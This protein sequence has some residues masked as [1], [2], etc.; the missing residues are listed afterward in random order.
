MSEHAVTAGERPHGDAHGGGP[1]AGQDHVAPVGLYL[2]VFAALMVL[3]VATVAASRVD[4]GALNTPVALGIAV[5][6]AALVVLFFMHVRWSPRLIALVF[7][8]SLFWLFHMLAGTAADYLSRRETDPRLTH[9]VGQ[10]E[11]GP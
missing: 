1:A 2:A 8:A 10:R 11:P 9:P 3:T 7:V 6:K 4:L 5:A